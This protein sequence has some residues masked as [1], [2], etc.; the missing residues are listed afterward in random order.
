MT[1]QILTGPAGSP[2]VDEIRGVAVGFDDSDRPVT[3]TNLEG[4]S[5]RQRVNL[6]FKLAELLTSI[7]G[8][9][10]EYIH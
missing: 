6:A 1:H 2:K 4:L 5:T 7:L 8:T 9:T 3:A 10:S